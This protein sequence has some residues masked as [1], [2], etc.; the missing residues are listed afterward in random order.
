[1][2]FFIPVLQERI[3]GKINGTPTQTEAAL[4][5]S[6]II[7]KYLKIF[8]NNSSEDPLNKDINPSDIREIQHLS[9]WLKNNSKHNSY[10]KVQKQYRNLKKRVESQRFQVIK[11]G[12]YYMFDL[13][14]HLD[15]DFSDLKSPFELSEYQEKKW[16]SEKAKK[17]S[18]YILEKSHESGL[19]EPN[20]LRHFW[21]TIA[22]EQYNRDFY[23]LVCESF[24][25]A[26]KDSQIHRMA[27]Q[28]WYVSQLDTIHLSPQEAR[29]RMPGNSTDGRY[30]PNFG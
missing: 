10:D 28:L 27:Q 29:S 19:I 26:H 30:A 3:R 22:R 24:Q 18:Q 17:L 11:D 16:N 20:R 1:L 25:D 13:I 23:K 21:E 15:P 8:A 2:D 4:E 7:I 5:F 14:K 12:A 6:D 9:Q